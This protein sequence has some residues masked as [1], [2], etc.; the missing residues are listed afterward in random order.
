M[1]STAPVQPLLSLS[2]GTLAFCVC[3]GRGE[4][5]CSA[6]AE[7]AE[8]VTL[9]VTHLDSG[10]QGKLWRRNKKTKLKGWKTKKM[11]VHKIEAGQKGGGGINEEENA[12]KNK[13]GSRIT[14]V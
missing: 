12:T 14:E 7:E 6:A 5:A 3:S 8:E 13:F 10:S 4:S 11:M 1:S 2:R 9:P